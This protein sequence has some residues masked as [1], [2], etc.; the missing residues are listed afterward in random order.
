MSIRIP[1]HCKKCPFNC[2]TKSRKTCVLLDN[3]P[4]R[5]AEKRATDD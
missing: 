1:A 4:F 3:K 2:T 5:D